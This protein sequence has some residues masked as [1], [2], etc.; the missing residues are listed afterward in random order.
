[1]SDKLPPEFLFFNTSQ[2]MEGGTF[3][4]LWRHLKEWG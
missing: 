4:K 3:S 2:Q 1:M